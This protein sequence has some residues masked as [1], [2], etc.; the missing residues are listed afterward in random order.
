MYTV[1]RY[2]QHQREI[3]DPKGTI[4]RSNQSLQEKLKNLSE[5]GA[6]YTLQEILDSHPVDWSEEDEI[7]R[8][9]WKM[10]IAQRRPA[11]RGDRQPFSRGLVEYR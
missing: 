2:L 8:T 11:K 3:I 1:D 7:T 9:V 4:L 10:L 6:D 5:I